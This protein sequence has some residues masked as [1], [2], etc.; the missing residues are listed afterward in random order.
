[1]NDLDN[2]REPKSIAA[3]DA[4]GQSISFT[5]PSEPL[6]CSL[7]RVLAASKPAGNFLELGSG[8]GLSTAWILDGMDAD[9][10]LTTKNLCCKFFGNIWD[11][12]PD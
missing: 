9:A 1:M 2:L 6:T 7:L 4:G 8:T 5:M 11:L 10:R 3:I 12:I